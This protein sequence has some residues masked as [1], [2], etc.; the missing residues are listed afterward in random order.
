MKKT[1]RISLML[2]LAILLACPQAQAQ[3]L[4]REVTLQYE[5]EALGYILTDISR[6]YAV[7]FAYSSY[8]IPV[9]KRVSIRVVNLPLS[10]ALDSLFAGTAIVYASIGGQIALKS[11]PERLATLQNRNEGILPPRPLSPME[12]ERIR[13]GTNLPELGGPLYRKL[14]GGDHIEEVELE[15]FL[16]TVKE[17]IEEEKTPPPPPRDDHRIAQVSLLP[18]LGTN[19]ER[20]DVMTNNFSFNVFWGANG[21]VDGVEVGGLV[22]SI[23]KDVHGIQVAG[24]G[25]IVGGALT[26]TQLGGF[27]NVNEGFTKG[28]Q[29][30]GFFNSTQHTDAVQVAGLFNTASQ[31][32]AGVQ[33]A[34]A[35]NVAAG[36]AGV[37]VATLFNT[38]GDTTR[39]QVATLFNSA[40]DV[41]G[42]QVSL[43]FNKARKVNGLQ[44]GLV[45]VAD[46][47]GGV[48][49][50]VLN[51]VKR[52]YNR[53]EFGSGEALY[54][55]LG[56]KLG[57]PR[58]YNVIQ[59]GARWD[60]KTQTIGEE[61]QDGVFMS[62]GLG[63]G[64]GTAL[65]LGPRWQMNVEAVAIHINETERWTK[66][67][68]LLNQLRLTFDRRIGARTSLFFGPVGN[69][70]VSKR[71]DPETGSVGS[72]VAPYAFYDATR[73]A[74]NTQMWVGF[75][76][77]VRF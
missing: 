73:G 12:K 72:A 2:F 61:T 10:T 58:F 32:A 56:F 11:D 66:E 53:L 65:T 75:Q 51:F 59:V 42:G 21:G 38:S 39:T 35:F 3:L 74:T 6:Q 52:G 34:G 77:G 1:G 68:N 55:H 37:Q 17:T 31:D 50:G 64:L 70:M 47:V 22:N 57:T 24:L 43:L 23:T 13:L 71:R 4:S 69:L 45:N 9:E 20:S 19:A 46:T 16:I 33:V 25:N 36:K 67:L 60:R 30:A 14:P 40:R 41:S 54:T 62:W 7:N 8:Y 28:F 27:F 48:S 76:G 26:G 63:Y 5:E 49:F 15:R 18:F 44:V 29:L